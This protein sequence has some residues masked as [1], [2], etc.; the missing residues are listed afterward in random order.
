[1][2]QKNEVETINAINLFA[3]KFFK[4]GGS[5]QGLR[6]IASNQTL[7]SALISFGESSHEDFI[8]DGDS[9]AD[10]ASP[11]ENLDEIL[12]IPLVT[13]YGFPA[14]LCNRF[15]EGAT[16]GDLLGSLSIQFDTIEE[17]LLRERGIGSKTAEEVLEALANVGIQRFTKI[18]PD[19]LKDYPRRTLRR[20]F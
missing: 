5:P 15:S 11:P 6:K 16:V 1:M 8:I 14:R 3:Q 20:R 10:L 12:E 7:M 17:A 4:E 9:V 2:P 18:P 13:R 19:E